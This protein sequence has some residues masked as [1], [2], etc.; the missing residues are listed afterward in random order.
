[1]DESGGDSGGGKFLLLFCGLA[2]E[3]L[4]RSHLKLLKNFIVSQ[5]LGPE[6]GLRSY[7][8]YI[9]LIPS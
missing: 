7:Y 1:M 6:A 3:I 8:Q 5:V 4:N 2:G 9:V